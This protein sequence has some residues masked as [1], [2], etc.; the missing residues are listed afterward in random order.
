MRPARDAS[1]V[2]RGRIQIEVD[3]II[4]TTDQLLAMRPDYDEVDDDA[5]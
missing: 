3:S 5:Y 4:P 1:G 2:T